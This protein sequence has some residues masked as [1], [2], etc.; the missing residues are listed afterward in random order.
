MR[1]WGWGRFNNLM[2]AL[3]YFGDFM[4][5]PSELGILNVLKYITY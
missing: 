2:Y 1:G 5:F 4:C 3:T